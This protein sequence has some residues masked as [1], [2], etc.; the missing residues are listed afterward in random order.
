VVAET[1]PL[2]A[3]LAA[4]CARGRAAH[5]AITVDDGAFAAHLG[6]AAAA[7]GAAASAVD[8]LA[9]ED[10]YLACGCLAGDQAAVAALTAQHGATI[11][12]AIARVVRGPDA[13]EVEQ[14]LLDGLVVGTAASPPK[15]ATYAGKAPLERWLSVAAQRAALMWLRDNREEARAR[16][17]AAGEPPLG[18]HTHPETA[19]LKERY[20]GDFARALKEALERLPE[21]ERVI[22]RLQLVSGLSAEKIG[23]MFGVTQPTVSRW[24]AAAREA[25][26]DDIKATLGQ[27]LGTSSDELASLAGMVA[28]RLDLSLSTLLRSG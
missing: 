1:A 5:P 2:A 7:A 6:R 18:G 8:G 21:R 19:Y 9:V 16:D 11:R 15:L 23:T 10:L 20:R 28:S 26:L 17:G 3:A 4:A 12:A 27:Q 24:L 22:L 25:L 13:A 14:Q